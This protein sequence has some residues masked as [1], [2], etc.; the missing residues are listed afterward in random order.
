M[1]GMDATFGHLLTR[2]YVDS[3]YANSSCIQLQSLYS[4]GE[5]W[6]MGANIPGWGGSSGGWVMHPSICPL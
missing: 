4:F 1:V 6:G 5:E 3:H 2:H